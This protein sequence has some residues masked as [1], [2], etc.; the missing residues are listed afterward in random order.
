MSKPQINITCATD[1]NYVPYC[2]V[3]LTSVF[4]NHKDCEVNVYIMIDKPLKEENQK[5]FALLAKLYCQHI[6][7]C[8]VDKSYFENFP[9]KGDGIDYW[10]IVTYYRL[11]AAELLPKDVDLVLYLDCDTIVNGSL[12]NL[13]E[14]KWEGIGIGAVPDMCT[15]WD[16]YYDRL[17][18][19]KKLGYF[20]AGV[21]M[22][23]LD[24]WRKN[25]IGQKCLIFLADN[26]D[27]IFNNDQDV[28]N[29]V[30]QKNKLTLSVTYNYQIQL[31][32]P[33]FYHT[34]SFKL[35]EDIKNTTNPIIIHYAAELK[36][37]MTKYYSYPFNDVWHIYKKISPWKNMLDSLPHDRKLQAWIKRYILWPMGFYLKKPEMVEL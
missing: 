7:Y 12:N 30:L 11:Y 18:Y 29:V 9:L 34:F 20:N 14:M 8:L 10:S 2:G 1:D 37:W 13:F 26:Y 6:H 33:Y 17:G 21:V 25:N 22:I 16:A 31:R 27:K 3:M 36:P 19:N 28:L 5:K 4:E 35:K 32:M 15:E 23:N 24:Y